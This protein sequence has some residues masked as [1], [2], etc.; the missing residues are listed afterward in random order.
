M[1]VLRRRQLVFV[2]A[3]ALAGMVGATA[4]FATSTEA[5]PPRLA[6]ADLVCG[7]DARASGHP[8]YAP[9][10]GSAS[11]TDLIAEWTSN[12]GFGTNSSEIQMDDDR[13]SSDGGQLVGRNADGEPVLIADVIRNGDKWALEEW[14]TCG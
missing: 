3:V 5:S 7:S 2:A 4:W 1:P 14:T 13:V 6:G 11:V 9:G 10:L 8:Y 12:D